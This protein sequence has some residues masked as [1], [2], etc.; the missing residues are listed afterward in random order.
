VLCF[1]LVCVLS[2]FSH[3]QQLI[4][5]LIQFEEDRPDSLP[6]FLHTHAG[7]FQQTE[8][9][10]CVIEYNDGTTAAVIGAGDVGWTYAGE[11]TIQVPLTGQPLS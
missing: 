2:S 1:L 10:V 4:W 7:H 8:T 9:N 3:P 6:S 5:F 11:Q